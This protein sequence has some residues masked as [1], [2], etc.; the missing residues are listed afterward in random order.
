M[1]GR[2]ASSGMSV[3]GKPY[4]SEYHTV[5][6]AGR[7]KFIKQNDATSIRTPMETMTRGRVY[8]LIGRND[9]P[10]AV[11][12]YDKGNKRYKQIDITGKAHKINGKDVLPHVHYGYLHDEQ[13][14]TK[15]L[16]AKDQRRVDRLVSY[17]Y[18]H[19]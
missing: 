14:G 8:V 5:L 17:W 15:A 9:V 10:K 13:G 6:Q 16:N 11:T 3:K 4:G 12:F 19:K 1:G 7:V 2:G 18:H